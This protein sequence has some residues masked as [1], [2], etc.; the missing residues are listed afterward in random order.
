VSLFQPGLFQR[1]LFQMEQAQVDEPVITTMPAPWLAR[2]DAP[3][4][5][6]GSAVGFAA[7]LGRNTAKRG[8]TREERD[9][10]WRWLASRH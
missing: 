5:T 1:G 10:E 9:N 8:R 4:R 3:R 6:R 2:I 7:P